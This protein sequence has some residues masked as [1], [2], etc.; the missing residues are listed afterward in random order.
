MIV[1][2]KEYLSCAVDEIEDIEVSLT[3]LAAKKFTVLK[4]LSPS[5]RLIIGAKQ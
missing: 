2:T 4:R 5:T 1:I 3:I